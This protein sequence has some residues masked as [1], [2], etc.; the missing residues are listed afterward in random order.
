MVHCWQRKILKCFAVV[1]ASK[2]KTVSN[3][4]LLQ[5][6]LSQVCFICQSIF[7][8]RKSKYVPLN[9]D[10]IWCM[11]LLHSLIIS[12]CK[13]RV[14]NE[15]SRCSLSDAVSHLVQQYGVL[16][17]YPLSRDEIKMIIIVALPILH[18]TIRFPQNGDC[19]KK[20]LL[21]ETPSCLSIISLMSLLRYN[22]I[23]STAQE[24]KV[25]I[26]WILSSL[27]VGLP[28]DLVCSAL[29][30]ILLLHGSVKNDDISQYVNGFV[31]NNTWWQKNAVDE[32]IES[33][34]PVSSWSLYNIKPVSLN[35][36]QIAHSSHSAKTSDE[37][38]M[39]VCQSILNLMRLNLSSNEGDVIRF[40]SL[41]L[42]VLASVG[43]G[44][45]RRQDCWSPISEYFNDVKACVNFSLQKIKDM[46]EMRLMLSEESAKTILALAR[47]MSQVKSS[48]SSE[49]HTHLKESLDQL[50]S[51]ETAMAIH[52]SIRNNINEECESIHELAPTQIQSHSQGM[53]ITV[54][55]GLNTSQVAVPMIKWYLQFYEL[56]C[57]FEET[58]I[59]EQTE[60]LTAYF[61]D[62]EFFL[63]MT[64][65]RNVVLCQT[66]CI[67][68][69]LGSDPFLAAEIIQKVPFLDK[70]KGVFSL[71]ENY[72]FRP[73]IFEFC[74]K[75]GQDLV[76]KSLVVQDKELSSLCAGTI[77]SQIAQ[78][79]EESTEETTSEDQRIFCAKILIDILEVDASLVP[80]T[81]F[82]FLV[83]WLASQVLD[84]YA[85]R[86]HASY[87]FP[88]LLDLFKD[89]RILFQ[90]VM[91]M[92]PLQANNEE[93]QIH[94]ELDK[95]DVI[96]T[97]VFT[98]ARVAASIPSLEL[99]CVCQLFQELSTEDQRSNDSILKAITWLAESLQYNHAAEYL[100]TMA[101]PLI[102][103]LIQNQKG[104]VNCMQK[105]FMACSLVNLEEIPC[106][107]LILAFLIYH[108][109]VNGVK[110]FLQYLNNPDFFD[111]LNLSMSEICAVHLYMS[112]ADEI[113]TVQKEMESNISKMVRALHQNTN[114]REIEDTLNENLFVS[115]IGNVRDNQGAQNIE[116]EI[117]PQDVTLAV[118]YAEFMISA[119]GSQ[120]RPLD[121]IELLIKIQRKIYAFKHPRHKIFAMKSLK[122]SI[123]FTLEQVG[124][125]GVLRQV[126]GILSNLMRFPTTCE[127]SCELLMVILPKA[128]ENNLDSALKDSVI[129]TIGNAIPTILSYIC[130]TIQLS[131]PE[132]ESPVLKCIKL[133]TCNA[134]E[135]LNSFTFIL[136]PRVEPLLGDHGQLDGDKGS[137]RSLSVYLDMFADTVK[138]MSASTRSH[139]INEIQQMIGELEDIELINS[140]KFIKEDALWK[141]TLAADSTKDNNLIDFAGQLLSY[142]GPLNPSLLSF[143][144]K[145][146]TGLNYEKCN[147]YTN[148]DSAVENLEKEVLHQLLILLSNYLV[149]E[150]A[151]VASEAFVILQEILS[152]SNGLSSYNMLDTLSQEHLSIFLHGCP[153]VMDTEAGARKAGQVNPDLWAL[154]NVGYDQWITSICENILMMVRSIFCG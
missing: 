137:R 154:E 135:A 2:F 103:E 11:R 51:I 78:L 48:C 152:T 74:L 36:C 42:A 125:P 76:S 150:D 23:L 86:I 34:A 47:A 136:D 83:D 61:R 73:E 43:D 21:S 62:N 28:V 75:C 18:D 44:T 126:L 66:R 98:L 129:S 72:L 104:T 92:L 117:F 139:H 69:M 77:A 29:G 68:A 102:T 147:K 70:G 31:Q 120:P 3:I 122:C 106:K 89:P 19:L 56:I 26:E 119:D 35:A 151:S 15:T 17:S 20:D 116:S 46:V 109:S 112:N 10:V 85:V 4:R 57:S 82:D 54:T 107:E 80:E 143:K 41:G 115:I 58:S 49:Y 30:L 118:K 132:P 141:I 25:Y 124:L 52:M 1:L 6:R 71:E 111:I 87:V 90:K 5:S 12:A 33:L 65:R 50:P 97:M 142:F 110:G 14:L 123:L 7:P 22:K 59:L 60:S 127:T 121:Y 79:I 32:V 38:N 101:E 130:D 40:G 39:H 13:R 27:N 100:E 55:K 96:G 95:V 149:D 9:A 145:S 144:P 84:R 53:L 8:T 99:S 81:S 37:L 138:L 140:S 24:S 94:I 45:G 16:S 67:E 113:E 148:R 153:D 134:P 64:I 128:L 91:E 114:R 131:K 93:A 133:L 146:K 88:K 105:Y 108:R 63:P